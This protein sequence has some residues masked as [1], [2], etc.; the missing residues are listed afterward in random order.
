M[1]LLPPAKY[2][3][4]Q[5]RPKACTNTKAAAAAAAQQTSI[6]ARIIAVPDG[7]IVPLLKLNFQRS[8]SLLFQ[9]QAEQ[10][11]KRRRGIS[12]YL[13]PSSKLKICML[14]RHRP[15]YVRVAT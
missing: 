3:F 1:C 12:L 9:W 4:Y 11:K 6:Y 14:D 13:A 10:I 8:L 5:W 7:L 15:M 2:P